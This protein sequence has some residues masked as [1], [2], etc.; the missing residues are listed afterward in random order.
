MEDKEFDSLFAKK[1]NGLGSQMN[2]DSAWDSFKPKVMQLNAAGK[3]KLMNLLKGKGAIIISSLVV[4]IVGIVGLRMQNSAE[5]GNYKPKPQKSSNNFITPVTNKDK[6]ETENPLP[7]EPKIDK[8]HKRKP[9]V[10]IVE[11]PSEKLENIESLKIDSNQIEINNLLDTAIIEE[12]QDLKL[13]NE[14]VVNDTAVKVKN[15][16]IF[17]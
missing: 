6:I 11:Q 8:L 2:H 14:K 3:G 10:T 17:W 16:F 4:V 12:P 5:I 15:K 1:L 13:N 7:N 9:E